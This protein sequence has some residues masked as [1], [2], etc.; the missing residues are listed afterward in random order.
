MKWI[1]GL[2]LFVLMS[3]V[4]TAQ[5]APRP[6][7][8]DD[9]VRLLQDPEVRA[10]LEKAPGPTLVAAQ[11]ADAELATWEAAT[12]SRIDGV[13]QAI[14][15]IPAEVMAAA[16]R[17]REDALSHGRLPVFVAFLGLT[18]IGLFAESLFA[19]SRRR[20]EGLQERLLAIG[21]FA[22]AMA[23]VYFAF[24]WPA[25]PR[26][27]LLVSLLAL[28]AYRAISVLLD[29]AVLTI[30]ARR[31]TKI[32]AGAAIV[33]IA[34]AS[35]GRPLSV[36]PSV[37]AA[38]SFCF[39]I[40][41]LILAVEGVVSSSERTL[42]MRIALCLAFVIIWALW[43][44]GLRGLFWLGVYAMTLPSV[45][46]FAG[47]TAADTI[48]SEP[49]STKRV[50]LVR[51]SRAVVV[52]VAVAWVAIVWRVDPNS[53]VHSDPAVAS[54]AYGLLK[55]VVVLLLADLAWHLAKSWIDRRLSVQAEA[56]N[57]PSQ[58]ARRGRLRTL[59]PIFRNVL[60]VM[61]A[62]IAGLI[63]LAE[64]GVEIGPL[65]AGAGIFGVA[66]GFGSQTLVKDVISGVF[67]MLDDAFRVGEYIQAKS[68]KGTV[69]GFSLRSVRLRH[70]RGPVFT[71]PFGELGA[72]ENMSRD[73]VIDKFRVNVSYDTDIEKARKLAKKIGAELQADP[74]LGPLFIQPLKMKGVEEFGDYGIVLSFAMTTVPGM[75]TYIRRK[76]YAKIREA[77]QAN[78][79]E[80]ATPSV[81]VGGDDRDGAA[82]AAAAIRTQQAKVVAAEG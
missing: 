49:N 62:V 27:V 38:I 41:L 76:A 71:V 34:A 75:Q 72:V 15:R 32:F 66:L 7:K 37:T 81:Q 6:Q 55:S 47:Q 50:L 46:R 40:V 1:G 31:R 67:Y 12:R 63:V 23:A 44:V 70:H 43:C 45:L 78:G 82:A 74:E 77:F 4:A 30:S 14:P 2:L 61:V 53:L 42:R 11:Q 20:S 10:W 65:I 68:Y 57:D 80:F 22:V 5:E 59:L 64:L 48:P 18:A 36:D 39:S 9:L 13:V 73:W 25:L 8:V 60:A 56:G 3:V 16:A 21:V 33:G 51:G 79:I 54:V 19:R 17:T 28:S 58:A 26:I 52:A 35:L 29:T 24:D 69:E